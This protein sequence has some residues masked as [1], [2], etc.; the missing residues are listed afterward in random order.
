[1]NRSLSKD[2]CQSLLCVEVPVVVT[3]ARTSMA[4]ENVLRLVPGVMIQFDKSCDSPLTVEVGD[5][6]IAEGEVVKVGDKFGLR[7]SSILPHEE[8]FVP[9]QSQR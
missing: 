1:M 6:A 2:F 9:V 5:Q 4:V 8:R 3:L 7:I